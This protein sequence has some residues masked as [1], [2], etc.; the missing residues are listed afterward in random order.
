MLISDACPHEK[1]NYAWAVQYENK[2]RSAVLQPVLRGL[3]VECGNSLKSLAPCCV[4]V[5]SAAIRAI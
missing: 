5:A 1:I 2:A 4:R 3:I